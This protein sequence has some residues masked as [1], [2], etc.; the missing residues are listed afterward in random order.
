M[1]R[2]NEIKALNEGINVFAPF[3]GISCGMQALE[4]AGIKVKKYYAS[5]V[6]ETS[7][8]ISKYHYPN[9]IHLGDIRNVD[10]EDIKDIDLI[11]GGSPCQNFSFCGTAKGAITK[12][13]I[14]VTSLEKY[15]ELKNQGFEFEGQSYLFWEYVRILKDVKPKYFLLENVKMKKKWEDVITNTLGVEPILINSGLVSA[16][17]RPRLY[18]T[19]IKG[20]EQPK[21]KGLLIKDVLEDEYSEKE[22]LSKKIQDRFRFIDNSTYCIGTT[23]PEFR[24][25]GQR[26][27]VFG[28]NNKMGC[29]V[30][31][32]Y[33]QPK[34]VY[35]NNYLRKISPLE[36]ERFQ[37][38]PDNYTQYGIINGEKKA[39]SHTKRFEAIGNGWT[40][41][42]I[43]HILTYLKKN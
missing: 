8:G 6:N 31:T 33:K 15:L 29:L 4:K 34:Q 27:F 1:N 19:N 3:D 38:L 20:I 24:T 17:N 21:D 37:T 41:D 39:I 9:I 11:L 26:D 10:C 14:E 30:A 42:V 36:A 25:I 16:Q 43:T 22:I 32:D 18:W 7:I 5:E 2:D 12:E 23:K 13:G 35:H 40:V 28:D